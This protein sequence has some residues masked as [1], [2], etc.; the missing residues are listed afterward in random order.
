MPVVRWNARDERDNLVEVQA[1]IATIEELAELV[2]P[3][4]ESAPEPDEEV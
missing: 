4:A 3:D 2:E 1:E